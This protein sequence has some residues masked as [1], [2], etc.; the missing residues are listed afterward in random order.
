MAGSEDFARLAY[1]DEYKSGARRFDAGESSSFIHVAMAIA[2]MKKVLEW[3]VANIQETLSCLTERLSQKAVA[4]GL[5]TTVQPRVGHIIG[6]KVSEE[7]V[8]ALSKKLFDSQVYISFR[9]TDM[10]IAPHLYNDEHDI[11]KLF[12]CL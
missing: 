7:K 6:I 10:R 12:G 8:A 1:Y 2:G 5:E 9:G 3:G 4:A 11:D